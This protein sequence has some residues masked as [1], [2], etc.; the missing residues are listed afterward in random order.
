M[1]TSQ[2]IGAFGSPTSELVDRSE[3]WPARIAILNDYLRVPYA[4]GSSFASQFLYREF[5]KRGH[6]VTIVGPRDPT[7]RL[8]QLPEQRVE[9][10]SLPLRNHPGVYLPLPTASAL[11]QLRARQFD[12][13]LGQTGSEL[14]VAGTW[15]RATRGIPFLCVNTIHLPSVYNV[16]LPDAL[17]TSPRVREVFDERIIPW[18]ERHSARVY[19][20]GDGLI[21]LS[22]G[23][24]RY[25]RRRGVTVPI[26]VIPRSVEPRIFDAAPG[27][28]PFDAA[29][30]PGARL[31]VV[32]RHTREKNVARLL[33]V[34][35]RWIAPAVPEATLTLVG[36][37]PDHDAFRELARALGVADKSFFP[38]EHAVT[39]MPAFYRH[40][41]LFVYAS[42][43][44]TYGQVVGEALW[45][46][47]PV[48]AL[49]DGMGVSEQVE[50]GV[51]GVLVS[52]G[53][54]ERAADW[55]LGNEVIALL[56]DAGRRR[57]MAGAAQQLAHN[58]SNPAIGVARYS[59]AF[60]EAARHLRD[61]PP[62]SRRLDVWTSMARWVT[63]HGLLAAF[64]CVRRPALVNR[65]NRSQIDWSML[66]RAPAA[67]TN[68][69]AKRL[70]ALRRVAE[71]CDRRF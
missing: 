1:T 4:N 48:A 8:E 35:A 50:H 53:R 24:E 18:L 3:R 47:L 56:R 13:V 43:S 61:H 60:A 29:A 33:E 34:F 31:L 38:G 59:E 12:V 44:E 30:K 68:G 36:D 52:S 14:A 71:P 25:W 65:H 42:L 26:H 64:G 22:H 32:C 39:S 67:S 66:D 62:Q 57:R 2:A 7:S 23:L 17:N 37:G 10:P 27:P 49:A 16:I 69:G 54:D 5:I 58:R 6:E 55:R 19:N 21:V 45:C 9:F 63:I 40:A 15:L 28:D 51:N 41:D 70:S 11:D 20:R 46:G